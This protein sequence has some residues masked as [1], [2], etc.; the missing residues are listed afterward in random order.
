MLLNNK[1]K[2]KQM[3][4]RKLV[5]SIVS[6]YLNENNIKFSSK[7]KDYYRLIIIA[8]VKFL[9]EEF[10]IDK[11]IV[12]IIKES[13][14][15][16]KYGEVNLTNGKVFKLELNLN[17]SFSLI[18]KSIIHELTH[19]KQISKKELRISVDGLNILYGT[20]FTLPIIKY[21]EISKDL[22]KY[23]Y[24]PWEVEAYDNMS[25]ITLFNKII[26]SFTVG[27]AYSEKG[28]GPFL[29]ECAM[30][31]V[32]PNALSM[33]R[34]S[35]TSDDALNVWRKFETR[36][37]VK[38]ERMHSDEITHKKEDWLKSDFLGDNP[39]YR[40]KI[41]DLEDT[42]FFYNFGKSK[43]NNLL[44]IGKEYMSENNITEQD[45]EYMSWELES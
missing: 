23:R 29:Y 34:D 38:K 40:Q 41:F 45:V 2:Y 24:L 10:L 42:R 18:I 19:I 35:T 31:F 6:D 4:V 5:E 25:D 36:N 3:L 13:K 28:Y 7:I 27:G 37:D 17:Q 32:Y 33:S 1:K 11:D 26:N 14:N 12:I 20:D 39:E 44:Q 43:L 15:N 22:S 8:V 30:T 21:K 16:N 9:K